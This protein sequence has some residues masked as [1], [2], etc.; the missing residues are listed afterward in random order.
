MI[1]ILNLSEVNEVITEIENTSNIDRK[2][3][4]YKAFRVLDGDQDYFVKNRNMQIFPETHHYLR[5]SD[6][7]IVGRVIKKLAQSYNQPPMRMLAN[8]DASIVYNE[9]LN[10]S[11]LDSALIEF[12]RNYHNNFECALW[13][14]FDSDAASPFHFRC[15]KSFEYDRV[16]NNRGETEAVIMSFP[17]E[18]VTGTIYGDGMEQKI[19]DEHEDQERYYALWTDEHHV[20]VRKSNKGSNYMPIPGNDDNIN[21][22][23]KLP[24]F[25][26]QKNNA[27][28]QQATNKL[29]EKA[30]EWN[31]QNSVLNSYVDLIYGT[32][33][34]SHDDQQEMDVLRQGLYSFVKLPQTRNGNPTSLQHVSPSPDIN[35]AREVLSDQLAN[36]LEDNGI[37]SATGVR[38]QQFNSAL[39]RMI[40]NADVSQHVKQMK[41]RYKDLEQFVYNVTSLY[42]FEGLGINLL[43]QK[44][45]IQWPESK[46]L[47]TQQELISNNKVLLDA[48]VISKAEFL[49]RVSP[50]MTLE[51]ARLL[52]ED[53]KEEDGTDNQEGNQVQS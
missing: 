45:T 23:G 41:T 27:R 29:A 38:G 35:A 32:W 20:F 17:R 19:Q 8:E 11:N 14:D 40:A 51:Q 33:V 21:P 12:D 49:K 16:V 48:G 7:D 31:S 18:E 6:V 10:A 1:N 50:G 3:R 9:L 4:E 24:F 13:V 22:I 15:L 52:V 36:I 34:L 37:N 2:K 46:P 25:F 42:S 47:Q 39:E 28:Y 44:L 30:I 43:N 26:M 5:V 53:A